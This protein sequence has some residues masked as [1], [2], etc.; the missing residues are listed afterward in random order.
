MTDPASLSTATHKAARPHTHQGA[1]L[2]SL[3]NVL[4]SVGTCNSS[5]QTILQ[6]HSTPGV[7]PTPAVSSKHK[8]GTMSTETGIVTAIKS[9]PMTMKRPVPVG[10]DKEL[11]NP[12]ST[13]EGS[14]FQQYCAWCFQQYCAVTDSST[15]R[16][17]QTTH[18]CIGN[19]VRCWNGRCTFNLQHHD[20]SSQSSLPD[21]TVLPP[22]CT[23]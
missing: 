21:T 20:C 16:L 14:C 10:L 19:A 4:S 15:W 22:F 12:V 11:P 3:M 9:Y 23:C 5:D 17:P 6:A 2:R 18:V 7:A 8:P 13:S 1:H